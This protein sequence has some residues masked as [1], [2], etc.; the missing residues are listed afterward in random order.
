[1]KQPYNHTDVTT[2]YKLIGESVWHLQHLENVLSSYTALKILQRKR[3]KGSE[4]TETSA[5]K[6]LDGQQKQV[7]GQLIGSAKEHGTIPEHLHVRFGD[8]LNERNWVIHKCVINEYLSLRNDKDKNRLFLRIG[9]FVTE[10]NLLTKEIHDL[11]ESWFK[12][13]GYNLEEAHVNA[14]RILSNAEKS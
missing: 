3:D 9:K 8:F 10:A 5:Q 1:M 13:Q 4:V 12:E 2:L 14:G 7:L 11:F 6:S